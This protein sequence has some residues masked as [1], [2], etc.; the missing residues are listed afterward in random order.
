MYCVT[1]IVGG[2]V[3]PGSEATMVMVA[4][5]EKLKPSNVTEP[6]GFAVGGFMSIVG[7]V[8]PTIDTGMLSGTS[9]PPDECILR[10]MLY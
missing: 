1:G 2:P 7:V 5:G 3:M 6:P 9:I 4:P 10:K 8:L